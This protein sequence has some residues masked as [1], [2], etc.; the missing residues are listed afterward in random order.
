MTTIGLS[1][2]ADVVTASAVTVDDNNDNPITPLNG[3][4]KVNL[5]DL[6]S[7]CIACTN[8]ASVAI[9]T[10]QNEQA[11]NT[12]VKEDGSFVTDADYIAQGVI[13]NAIHSVSPNIR[14]IG[15][16]SAEEMAQHMK[17]HSESI[18]KILADKN[19]NIIQRTNYEVRLRYHKK[20]IDVCPLA[21][22]S[23]SKSSS[24]SL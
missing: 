17:S 12:R 3:V 1:G 23:S 18:Q 2:N 13:V 16:E 4:E 24:S 20:P 21:S 22:L 7:A 8:T 9:E 6:V 10:I 15:E 14:I 19:L 11:K 5:L